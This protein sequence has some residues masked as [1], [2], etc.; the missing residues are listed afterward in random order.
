MIR[1]PNVLF[2]GE[3]PQI[4]L[5]H[6]DI[7]TAALCYWRCTYSQYGH[8]QVV[9]LMLDD[10]NAAHTKHPTH[11][12]YTD[13][14][15]LAR[16]VTD[17][18][19]RHFEDWEPEPWPTVR[20]EQARFAVDSDSRRYQ[21]LNCYSDGFHIVAKWQDVATHELRTYPDINKG[22]MGVNGDEHYDL[23]TVICLCRGGFIEINGAV[24]TGQVTALERDGRLM[25]ST[26]LAFAEVWTKTQ[27]E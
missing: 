13:N 21:Q 23:S 1:N 19:N 9:V 26:F 6:N 4:V 8:G 18:F 14:A 27:M 2:C 7:A 3:N 16:Y 11:A 25:S 12:I 5:T 22:G 15:A 10:N 24:L 20:P 17:A